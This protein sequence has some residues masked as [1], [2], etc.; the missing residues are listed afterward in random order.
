MA[1]D[2]ASIN[3][4][5]LSFAGN[6]NVAVTVASAADVDADVVATATTSVDTFLSDANTFAFSAGFCVT[7]DITSVIVVAT[8]NSAVAMSVIYVLALV[9]TVEFASATVMFGIVFTT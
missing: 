1:V 9:Y 2:T 8:A 6:A 3:G 4:I 5:I 7:S